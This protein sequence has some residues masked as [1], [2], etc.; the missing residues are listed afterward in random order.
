MRI[1]EHYGGKRTADGCADGLF[2]GYPEKI[3]MEE[4]K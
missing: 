1:F 2:G 3:Y 4:M